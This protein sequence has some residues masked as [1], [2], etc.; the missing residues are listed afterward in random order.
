MDKLVVQMKVLRALDAIYYALAAFFVL[1]V[2]PSLGRDQ[3]GIAD[4]MCAL[5]A[6]VVAWSSFGLPLAFPGN[7]NWP[8]GVFRLRLFALALAGLTPLGIW[9]SADPYNSYL[10]VNCV[11]A[12]FA[13]AGVLFYLNLLVCELAAAS[14][15]K[16]TELEARVV[17]YM[18]FYLLLV[19]LAIV[20]VAVI[21]LAIKFGF[22]PYDVLRQITSR[23]PGPALLALVLPILM[24]MTLLF[25]V[26]GILAREIAAA[27]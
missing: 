9:W 3:L 7:S 14:G 1:L 16:G 25:R 13:A 21:L 10:M 18:L 22:H 6:F 8:S 20:T 19:P 27:E 24:A 26:R 12:V 15:N 11:L 5:P 23:L 17:R 2:H 4:I